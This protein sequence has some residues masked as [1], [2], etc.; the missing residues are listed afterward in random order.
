M[1]LN[2]VKGSVFEL[3]SVATIKTKY[4]IHIVDWCTMGFKYGI[5]YQPTMEN[6]DEKIKLEEL[7]QGIELLTELMKEV[8][9]GRI[10]K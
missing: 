3:A 4:A 10:E 5:N 8:L 9:G 2:M 7:K 1:R 6:E